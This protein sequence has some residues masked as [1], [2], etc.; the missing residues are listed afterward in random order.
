MAAFLTKRAAGDAFRLIRFPP[1][2]SLRMVTELTGRAFGCSETRHCVV[3]FARPFR[4]AWGAR[5]F[6]GAWGR[7]RCYS[8]VKWIE[9]V[10]LG[11]NL[12]LSVSVIRWRWHICGIQHRP[13]TK[14]EH[15]NMGEDN[16]EHP[17]A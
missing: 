16:A 4:M 12:F 8:Y 11:P 14:D 17:R 10:L 9:G 15:I 7:N 3:L 13:K 2:L 6:R 1:A 5:A